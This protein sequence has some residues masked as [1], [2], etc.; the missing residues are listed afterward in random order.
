M[1]SN[2]TFENSYDYYVDCLKEIASN[3]FVQDAK[4]ADACMYA[5]DVIKLLKSLNMDLPCRVKFDWEKSRLRFEWDHPDGSL[6]V[7]LISDEEIRSVV[8]KQDSTIVEVNIVQRGGLNAE[9]FDT[10]KRPQN[11]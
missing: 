4:L 10:S 3:I 8:H 7:F 11:V 6:V 1:Q 9:S 5:V 2:G